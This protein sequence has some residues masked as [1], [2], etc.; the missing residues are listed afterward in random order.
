MI[1]K[2]VDITTSFCYNIEVVNTTSVKDGESY[3]GK[4]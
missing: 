2:L 1:A 3:A 4:I